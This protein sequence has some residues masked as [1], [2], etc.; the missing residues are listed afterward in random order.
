MKKLFL[1]FI[2]FGIVGVINTIV[3]LSVYYVLL[4]LCVHYLAANLV[5]FVI[6]V[7][8]A[9]FLSGKFVFKDSKTSAALRLAKVYAA[10]GFT[11]LLGT[12]S[13]FV[14]VEIFGISQFIAPLLNMLVTVPTNFL[15]NKFW[16]F[17]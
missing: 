13:L 16:A 14:M 11:F 7:L 1:Q 8:N 2:K 17:R 6:S 5:A 9:F 4:W 3:F 15:V 10:Y 12:A